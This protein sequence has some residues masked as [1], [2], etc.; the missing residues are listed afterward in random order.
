M[1][2]ELLKSNSHHG[3]LLKKSCS[4]N[5]PYLYGLRNSTCIINLEK[6]SISLK[7]CLL[8]VKKSINNMKKTKNKKYVLFIM[9]DI[10]IKPLQKLI[11]SNS[12]KILLTK[13]WNKKISL[14]DQTYID[15]II[16]FNTKNNE[17]LLHDSKK[18]NIPV[19]SIVGTD[20]IGT[21]N[22]NY[23]IMINKK[24]IKSLFLLIYLFLNC[25]NE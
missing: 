7:R 20:F 9:N 8:L 5:F 13:S 19:I 25:N 16:C 17:N 6:T 12:N 1:L 24:S 23:P 11:G 2:K 14:K 10:N 18:L 22:I 4:K 3:C 21:N 15:L